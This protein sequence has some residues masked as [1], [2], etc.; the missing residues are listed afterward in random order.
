VKNILRVT[1]YLL[2]PI[3][4]IGYC[5]LQ[6][7]TDKAIRYSERVI[8]ELEGQFENSG[9]YP[10]SLSPIYAKLGDP[11][12]PIKRESYYII[13]DSGYQLRFHTVGGLFPEFHTY[14]S[15]TKEWR[16]QDRTLTS[17]VGVADVQ[18]CTNAAGA[19]YAGAADALFSRNA[20]SFRQ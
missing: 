5:S 20:F 15:K 18:G 4:A 16:V 10:K 13:T 3:A 1:L 6:S 14:D 12:P 11:T 2:L 19:G 7:D 8:A 17:T 9:N